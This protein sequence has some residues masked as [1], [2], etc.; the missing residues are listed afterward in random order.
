M[1]TLAPSS[2]DVES[3]RRDLKNSGYGDVIYDRYMV[4]VMVFQQVLHRR[5]RKGWQILPNGCVWSYRLPLQT[6]Q[7]LRKK[8]T[9]SKYGFF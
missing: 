5:H 8:E 9:Q 6:F 4:N 7:H 2:R 3:A 1:R